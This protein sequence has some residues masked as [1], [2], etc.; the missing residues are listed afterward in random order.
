MGSFG[1]RK[2]D[3]DKIVKGLLNKK[4]VINASLETKMNAAVNIVFATARAKRP[5]ITNAQAK[6]EGR[7]RI[8]ITNAKG[9]TRTVYKR[10]SDPNARLGVAVDTGDLQRSINKDVSW[11]GEKL[12]GTITAGEGLAYANAIEFGT[13]KMPARPFMRPAIN[14]QRETVKKIFRAKIDKL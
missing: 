3:V 12:Q 5:M 10:V 6:A 2:G 1:V 7:K 11:V 9:I 13:S 8:K 4:D 14:E